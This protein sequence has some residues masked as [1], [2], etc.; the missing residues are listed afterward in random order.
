MRGKGGLLVKH[1]GIFGESRA[2][3]LG[4]KRDRLVTVLALVTAALAG[5]FAAIAQDSDHNAFVEESLL[6]TAQRDSDALFR[7]IVQGADG[8]TTARMAE[9]VTERLD[10]NA[11]ATDQLTGRFEV[12]TG[13]AATLTGDQRSSI[14]R[15]TDQSRRS[16]A[17]SRWCRAE[18]S[19]R[20]PR[21]TPSGGLGR[22][23]SSRRC[24]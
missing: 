2:S 23:A 22:P 19:S 10:D 18:M 1:R 15:P 13:V 7:V 21:R 3:V 20:P 14:W 24:A 16:R 12:V 9:E 6:T 17:T 4:R 5:P 11:K 8:T